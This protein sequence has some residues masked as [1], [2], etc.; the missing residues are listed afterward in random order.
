MAPGSRLGR[1]LA[2]PAGWR[3]RLAAR[4]MT[5]VNGGMISSAVALLAVDQGNSVLEI[6]FGGGQTLGRLAALAA[7]RST[8]HPSSH[9]PSTPTASIAFC[10]STAC[11]TGPMPSPACVRSPGC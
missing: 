6:G 9:Y 11:R 8:R 2:R 3:G 1:Q 7:L 4:Q 5:V 10:R